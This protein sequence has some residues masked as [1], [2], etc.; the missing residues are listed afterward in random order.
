[1]AASAVALLT[2]PA[3]HARVARAAC[4]QV[5]ERFCVDYV[6]PQ[7]VSHYERVLASSRR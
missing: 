5:G 4:R 2:D 7:Y 1:M 3:L 6:V